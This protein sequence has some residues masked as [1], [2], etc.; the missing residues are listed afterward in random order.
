MLADLVAMQSP[1]IPWFKFDSHH[2][3][4]QITKAPTWQQKQ[5]AIDAYMDKKLRTEYNT[6]Q[7]VACLQQKLQ[8]LCRHLSSSDADQVRARSSYYLQHV[9][10]LVN[11]KALMEE[12][13]DTQAAEVAFQADREEDLQN[14]IDLVLQYMRTALHSAQGPNA[15]VGAIGQCRSAIETAL[16]FPK[17]PEWSYQLNSFSQQ[18]FCGAVA[19]APGG[20]AKRAASQLNALQLQ[21]AAQLHQVN[22]IADQYFYDKIMTSWNVGANQGHIQDK[23]Q[24]LLPLLQHASMMQQVSFQAAACQQTMAIQQSKKLEEE[25][26]A[27][28]INRERQRMAL[29]TMERDFE[30]IEGDID[31][32]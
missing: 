9:A 23:L 29:H 25:Q 22:K 4:S 21:N 17:P 5:K 10:A 32:K 26:A 6:D 15:R 18:E 1:K 28:R 11:Q 12:T 27:K 30:N 2:A 31:S 20:S 14:S 8:E 24:S 3:V 19:Q 13:G 16:A 7:N